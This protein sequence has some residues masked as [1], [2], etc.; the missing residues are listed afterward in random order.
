MPEFLVKR[1]K[2]RLRRGLI[3]DGSENPRL[4]RKNDS[5][6]GPERRPRQSATPTGTAR[7]SAEL[8]GEVGEGDKADV[9]DT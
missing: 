4:A 6:G 5:R 7:R 9:G 8:V 1:D 3:G 2:L